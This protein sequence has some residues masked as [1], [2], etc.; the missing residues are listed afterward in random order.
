MSEQGGAAGAPSYMCQ[1]APSPSEEIE[2]AGEYLEV[3]FDTEHTITTEYWGQLR[4]TI[5][6]NDE[7]Y[8]VGQSSSDDMW[9]PC[10]WSKLVW[11]EEGDQLYYCT[12]AFGH[13]TECSALNADEPNPNNLESGCGGFAWSQLTPR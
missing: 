11:H 8:A 7:N 13:E 6:N 9:S 2:V 10:G 3:A 12:A 4:L 1:D 5:V